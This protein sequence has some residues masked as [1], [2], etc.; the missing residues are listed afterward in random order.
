MLM[1]LKT[2]GGGDPMMIRHSFTM[3]HPWSKAPRSSWPICC[4][5]VTVYGHKWAIASRMLVQF[6]IG[7]ILSTQSPESWPNTI[8]GPR[9]YIG[10]TL[11]FFFPWCNDFSFWGL[12]RGFNKTKDI[13]MSWGSQELYFSWIERWDRCNYNSIIIIL[14]WNKPDG[15]LDWV[16]ICK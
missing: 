9:S 11:S 8:F 3:E 14:W 16:L 4:L 6:V 12:L 10:S 7:S 13:K 5:G 2:D 15:H 1:T